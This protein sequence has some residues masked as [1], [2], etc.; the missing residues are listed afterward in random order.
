MKK[1]PNVLGSPFSVPWRLAE[2]FQAPEVHPA[3]EWEDGAIRAIYYE[4]LPYQGRGTRVFAYYAVPETQAGQKVPAI[5]LV[6]GGGGTAFKEWVQLWT[7]RGYAAIAMD[8]EGR[9][10]AEKA[11]ANDGLRPK[12]P[13]SGPSRQGVFE[14][15]KLPKE[16]QWTYHAA[17]AVV[18]AHSWLRSLE[19]VDRN[20]IGVTG[21]SWGGIVT[22]IAA[23]IDPRFAFAIPVYGCGFLDEA[24]NQYGQS[25]QSMP[26]KYAEQTKRLWDPSSYLPYVHMPM[27]WVS[28]S[29]DPHFPMHLLSKS[30]E[31]ARREEHPSILSI[32]FE[33]GHSHRSGWK[34]DIIYRFADQIV[35]GGEAV[36][37][38]FPIWLTS[39][40]EEGT[41]YDNNAPEPGRADA[42]PT[43]DNPTDPVSIAT[44]DYIGS[45]GIVRCELIWTDDA[46]DWFSVQ[47]HT[48]AA[49][50]DRRT[51]KLRGSLPENAQACF[52]LTEDRLGSVVCSPILI[53]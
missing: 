13:W 3:A 47:W 16:D 29:G 52:F 11:E 12:H 28:W 45:T 9:L 17:G 19:Q 27:L 32:D 31:T 24:D 50:M 26:G 22:C 20:R 34:P 49:E 38:L 40:E 14:D 15:F 43:A 48:A 2:L 51:G 44:A 4:S 1:E 41:L 18:L 10:P 23:G 42:A 6:H 5:V 37:Q 30:Y 33:M 46:A 25:F 39:A 7:S 21:I 8:L 53:L 35:K 36:P